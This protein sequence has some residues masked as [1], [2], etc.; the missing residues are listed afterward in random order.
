MNAKLE[1][2]E[3]EAY[4]LIGALNDYINES[5]FLETATESEKTNLYAIEE[6]LSRFWNSH[7]LSGY[8]APRNE[9]DKQKL[10]EAFKWLG[11]NPRLD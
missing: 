7:P 4:D 9:A 6:R 3:A 5:D 10:R 2:T 1:L 8:P 11:N